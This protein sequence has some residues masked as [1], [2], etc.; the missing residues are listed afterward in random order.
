MTES[1]DVDAVLADDLKPG[2]KPDPGEDPSG[3][4]FGVNAAGSASYDVGTAQISVG[5]GKAVLLQ[6]PALT[7]ADGK[8]I[9]VLVSPRVLGQSA[10]V[11]APN[12]P[13]SAGA[14][15]SASRLPRAESPP[16]PDNSPGLPTPE[17]TG[18]KPAA[19]G[20]PNAP[21]IS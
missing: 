1:G 8:R 5:D 18:A 2:Q 17:P 21:N 3:Q 11:N 20:R 14:S 16:A 7:G 12:N 19:P 13:V 10:S 6:N 9:L 15:S 4:V